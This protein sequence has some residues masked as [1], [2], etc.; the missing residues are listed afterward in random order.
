MQKIL[1]LLLV[2]KKYFFNLK[3]TEVKFL[4]NCFWHN[5]I[6]YKSI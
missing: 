5:L 1:I 6:V 2:K 4:H 3:F